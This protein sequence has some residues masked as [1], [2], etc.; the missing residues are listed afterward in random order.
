VV[1]AGEDSAVLDSAPDVDG[2]C[3]NGD[4]GAGTDGEAGPQD[5]APICSPTAHRCDG[6]TVQ[7]C[8]DGGWSD[9]MTCSSFCQQGACGRPLSCSGVGSYCGASG[10]IDC[11]SAHE[12]DGGTFERSYD[13]TQPAGSDIYPA[14]V[15]SFILDDFEVTT[16]RF[17]NFIDA[18]PA[19]DGGVGDL[20]IA[21]SGKN[22]NDPND[23]GWD[24]SWT[25]LLPP[26]RTALEAALTSCSFNSGANWGQRGPYPINCVDWY[27]AFAFCIWDGGRLPTE[28]EWNYAAAGGGGPTGQLVFPWSTDPNDTSITMDDA[29]FYPEMLEKVGSKQPHGVGRWLQADLVGNVSEW[30]RDSYVDTYAIVPC[31][32]CADYSVTPFKSYRG[33][34]NTSSGDTSI[35]ASSRFQS[36]PDQ[37]MPYVG[38]RCARSN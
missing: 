20:P 33:G 11:C 19:D 16:A 30:V 4:A 1:E 34:D 22:P 18:Y 8:A 25:A 3:D 24:P 9:Q 17:G 12:V 7:I 38:I 31:N 26:N 29:V 28:A 13:I 15:S 36:A 21:H 35:A 2:A 32:D 5:A 37:Y 23:T 14:T 6:N 10:N 27:V